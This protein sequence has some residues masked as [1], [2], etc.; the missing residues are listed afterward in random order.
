MIIYCALRRSIL[1]I[2][3]ISGTFAEIIITA[4]FLVD[5]SRGSGWAKVQKAYVYIGK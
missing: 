5:W 1:T 4:K 2:L 3:G